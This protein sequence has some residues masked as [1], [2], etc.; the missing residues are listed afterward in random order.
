MPVNKFVDLTKMVQDALEN[1]NEVNSIMNLVLFEDAI[2]HILRIN[3]II[4][5]PQGN[6]LL[7]GVGGSGKQSLS[8]LAAFISSFEIFQVGQSLIFI[9]LNKI[10]IKKVSYNFQ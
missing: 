9:S 6:A 3:R 4:E 1:Y 2:C 10:N 5:S 8:R 7:I